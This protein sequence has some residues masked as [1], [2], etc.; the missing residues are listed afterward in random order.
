M[1][2]NILKNIE[3]CREIVDSFKGLL[4]YSHIPIAIIS[5]IL[6]IYVIVKDRK[7]LLSQLFFSITVIFALWS[8]LDL[9]IWVKYDSSSLV[10]YYWAPIE[11][12]SVLLFML[13][14]YFS[15]VFLVGKDF[16]FSSKLI[17]LLVISPMLVV[18]PTTLNLQVFDLQECIAI[19][20]PTY[21]FYVFSIKIVLTLWLIALFAKEFFRSDLQSRKRVL[22]LGLGIAFFLIAF[23]VA[24]YVAEKTEYFQLEMYGLFGMYV[25]LGS[26]LYV[27]V[28]FKTFNIKLIGAQALIVSLVTLIASH[29]F[30]ISSVTAVVLD[31]ITLIIAIFFG[32]FLIRSIK[33][34]IKSREALE[35]TTKELK[36]ANQRLLEIDRQKSEFVSFATHQLRAPLTAMKGYASMILEGDFGDI[37]KEVREGVNRMYDSTNTLASVVD[38]YLNIS[39]I[40]LGTMQYNFA[41]MDMLTLVS[42]VI[43]E[44]KPSI[45]KTGLKFNF[46]HKDTSYIVRADKDKLKQVVT[47]LIDNSLKYTPNGGIDVEL[48]KSPINGKIQLT[49]K[50]TGLGIAPD[51]IPN[52]FSKFV[53]AKN[54]N[55]SNIHGTGLGLYV[56]KEIINAHGGRIWV[57]SEGEGKGSTFFVEMR[58]YK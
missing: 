4:I 22:I 13:S 26:M 46:T 1:D 32:Y 33:K 23:I 36:I 58:E 37:N 14:I 53:R 44:L 16:P 20:N 43:S 48:V 29:L 18:T 11:I 41:P 47:N 24:G 31:I 56:A 19:E 30:Y 3:Y 27:I 51:V 54:G 49:V 38:D 6:G 45:D 8:F 5:F 39:R 17:F 35:V 40:E 2:Y 34:E 9:M 50:D 25:F 55:K 57:E 42:S 7:S 10:M 15:H 52:L 12:L 28:K 21:Q